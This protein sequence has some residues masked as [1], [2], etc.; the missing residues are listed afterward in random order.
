MLLV[1]SFM[2]F[3]MTS[4]PAIFGYV[5]Q[6][7][8]IPWRMISSSVTLFCLELSH[9]NIFISSDIGHRLCLTCYMNIIFNMVKIIDLLESRPK[10]HG[11]VL[12]HSPTRNRK[13]HEP[14]LLFHP[15]ASGSCLRRWRP[16]FVVF[17]AVWMSLGGKLHVDDANAQLKT[18]FSK[19]KVS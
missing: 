2:S 8:T 5:L 13:T 19:A 11:C 14:T 15:E 17:Y 12:S 18:P 7:S 4:L 1:R 16:R 3:S 10:A 9:R 6:C